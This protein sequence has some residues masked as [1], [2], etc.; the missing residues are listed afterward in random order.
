MLNR[1]VLPSAH[2]THIWLIIR[3]YAVG[4]WTTNATK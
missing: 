1:N 4:V 3:S 2:C